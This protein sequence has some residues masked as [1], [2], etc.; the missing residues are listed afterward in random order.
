VNEV[1]IGNLGMRGAVHSLRSAWGGRVWM[2]A[3]RRSDSNADPI[4]SNGRSVAS[5]H[6]EAGHPAG[7]KPLSKQLFVIL[8]MLVLSGVAARAQDETWDTV[9]IPGIC[10]YQIPSTLELQKGTYKKIND[11]LRKSVLE[12]E[13]TP[14]RVVAQPK[15]IN[16]F[17][18]VALKRYCRVI[19]ETERGSRSEYAK[20][21]EPMAL[22][23][24]ELKE[25]ETEIKSQ[26]QQGAALLTSKGIKMT[27]LSWQGVK[28]NRVNGVDAILTTYT[29]SIND[30]PSVLVRMYKIQ[31]NDCLHTITISYRESESNLWEADLEKVVGTFK[32]KKR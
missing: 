7:R 31:N 12:I 13:T 11:Q 23:A 3:W 1:H 8:C 24:A 18:P 9:S 25:L 6:K 29:R 28:I 32:F 16:D 15:G 17:D 22:S 20:L 26:L 27:I 21:D 5:H 10:T 14:D 2:G 4:R 30:A 19:V